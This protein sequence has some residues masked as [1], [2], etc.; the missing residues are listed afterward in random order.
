MDGSAKRLKME[1]KN[2]D[3]NLILVGPI[4]VK[5]LSDF[6]LIEL[7]DEMDE[8]SSN[9]HEQTSNIDCTENVDEDE[10]ETILI[11]DDDDSEAENIPPSK[12]NELLSQNR[13]SNESITDNEMETQNMAIPKTPQICDKNQHQTANLTCKSN[14]ITILQIYFI[15]S[16]LK[17]V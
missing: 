14:I 5:P 4:E 6:D 15:F 11:E 2:A 8:F 9:Y 17:I 3:D 10:M 12:M 13:S 16:R 7:D 1:H